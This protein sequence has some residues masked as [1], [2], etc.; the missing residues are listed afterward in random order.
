M[1]IIDFVH[2]GVI[3]VS[4]IRS[5]NVSAIDDLRRERLSRTHTPTGGQ[6]YITG[7]GR[8]ALK[9]ATTLAIHLPQQLWIL[10][11]PILLHPGSS[12]AA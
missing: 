4:V 11:W 3:S 12:G 10:P 8:N 6:K 9:I 5:K 7:M 1:G 2:W